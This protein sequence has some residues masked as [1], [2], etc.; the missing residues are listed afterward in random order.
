MKKHVLGFQE[1]VNLTICLQLVKVYAML[2][3]SFVQRSSCE[4]KT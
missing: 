2:Y 3:F 1:T 4:V